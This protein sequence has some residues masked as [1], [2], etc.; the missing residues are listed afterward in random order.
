M[1]R[2]TYDGQYVPIGIRGR[3]VPL[4]SSNKKRVKL[5]YLR[6]IKYQ[7]LYPGV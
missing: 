1:G 5:S 7:L 2:V 6:Y 3:Y 4:E